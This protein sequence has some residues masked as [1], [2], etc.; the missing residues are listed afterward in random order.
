MKHK[1]KFLT[2]AVV[3]LLS[4]AAVCFSADFRLDRIVD[5][6]TLEVV[7]GN[8]E[9]IT[10]DL[11]GIDAPEMPKRNAKKGQ[12]FCKQARQMLADLI[13]NKRFSFQAHS[14]LINHYVLAVV[15]SEGKDVNLEMIKAGFAEVQKGALPSGFDV[16]PYRKE[17]AAAKK[18]EKGMWALGRVYIS[19]T[20][21]RKASQKFP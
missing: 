5:G 11:V 19:P 2:W 3:Y 7:T 6:D 15:Y 1:T 9:R 21:W 14:A 17:E 12:P 13:V 16:A 18:K 4:A 20:E 10:V 8:G